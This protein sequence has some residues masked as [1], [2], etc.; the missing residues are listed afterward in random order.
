MSH[1]YELVS[2]R[3]ITS[4]NRQKSGSIQLPG[5]VTLKPKIWY[6]NWSQ[7]HRYSCLGKF[8]SSFFLIIIRVL[9]FSSFIGISESLPTTS[10]VKMIDIWMIATLLYPFIQVILHTKKE[11][12]KTKIATIVSP[13]V[14][15]EV[16]TDKMKLKHCHFFSDWVLPLLSVL[17]A[18]GFWLLGITIYI[19]PLLGQGDRDMC[20]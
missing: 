3:V 12:L 19:W 4:Q 16:N 17:F 1:P 13:I 18:V 11:I 2:Q 20:V 5:G 8:V 7:S 15:K 10:Y 6:G 9:S 14:S